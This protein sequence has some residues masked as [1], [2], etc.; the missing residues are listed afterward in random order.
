MSMTYG[1]EKVKRDL[2]EKGYNLIIDKEEFKNI[3]ESD[4]TCL[5]REGY[6]Y[7][8][9]Y[10]KIIKGRKP[11]RFHA[12]NPFTIY[13]INV[14]L[15]QTTNGDYICVTD[16][17]ID[18]NSKLKIKH[19]KCGRIFDSCWINL[20]R[21]PSEKEPNR[22]GTRC[23]FCE[24]NQLESTH[25]LV[26]KQVWIHEHTD[27]IAEEKSCRNPITNCILPTDIVNHRLKIAI[28]I[29]SWFH[30]FEKQKIKDEIKEKYWKSLDYNFYAVDQRDYTVLEMIQLFFPNII[31]IP[32]Y[33]DFD[34]SNKIDDIGIQ[35]M[36]DDGYKIPYIANYY[37]IV[38]KRIY[39]AIQYGRIIYPD[40]YT[41]ACFSTIVQLDLNGKLLHNFNSISEASNFNNI[42]QSNISQCLQRKNY[43][44]G[45]YLWFYKSDFDDG[46]WFIP[47][48]KNQI[49]NI[50]VDK[51][52]KNNNLICSYSTVSEAL[53]E[54]K[55]SGTDILRVVNGKRKSCGGFIWKKSA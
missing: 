33:I 28:E 41:N 37:N 16:T 46:N 47:N 2:F 25:A 19:V 20:N 32:D 17:Y 24:A 23:P 45:G 7:N 50:S 38:P 44:S 36:L 18:N 52:D 22:H 6:K 34:Y 54:N 15:N 35:K 42:N 8:I 12:N 51:Y 39:D 5:D 9:C 55:C 27:T 49:Y 43:Y 53:K 48:V 40:T 11:A 29:Q 31:K 3:K 13:N 1:Y 30:D 4:L 14:F 21:K 10:N 26:L